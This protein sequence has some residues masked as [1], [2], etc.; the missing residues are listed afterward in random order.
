[1]FPHFFPSSLTDQTCKGI[2][3]LR[4]IVSPPSDHSS[5]RGEQGEASAKWRQRLSETFLSDGK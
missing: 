3:A 1:M 5:L 2:K 4:R